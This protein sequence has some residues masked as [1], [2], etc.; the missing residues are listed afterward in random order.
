MKNKYKYNGK[1]ITITTKY[2]K[3]DNFLYKS[4]EIKVDWKDN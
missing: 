2:D 1:T 3:D 4:K